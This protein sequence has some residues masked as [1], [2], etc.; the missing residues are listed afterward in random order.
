MEAH[1]KIFLAFT[2]YGRC[3]QSTIFSI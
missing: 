3:I 2:T 1:N